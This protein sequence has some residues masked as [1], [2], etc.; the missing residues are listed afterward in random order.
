MRNGD[1]IEPIVGA[2]LDAVDRIA[3]TL[4]DPAVAQAAR[5]AV[6]ARLLGES[7]TADEAASA[8]NDAWRARSRGWRLVRVQ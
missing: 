6:G 7:V 4:P 2:M 8:I 3:R 5:I 1:E